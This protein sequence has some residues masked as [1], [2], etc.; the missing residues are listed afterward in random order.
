MFL[1]PMAFMLVVTLT[2][3]G[4]SVAG[5]SR[6]LLD[7]TGGMVSVLQLVIALL[8]LALSLVL[9]KEGWQSLSRRR[10]PAAQS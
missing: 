4:M 9:V 3:L 1:L 7:G 5:Q 2:S 8:L 6:K 10:K